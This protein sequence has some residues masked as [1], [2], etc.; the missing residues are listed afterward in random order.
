MLK[1]FLETTGKRQ[2]K[3]LYLYSDG[4]VSETPL[5]DKIEIGRIWG[6]I[7]DTEDT[8]TM[9]DKCAPYIKNAK[10]GDY[11]YSDGKISSEYNQFDSVAGIV[12]WVSFGTPKSGKRALCITVNAASLSWGNNVFTKSSSDEDGLLNTKNIIKRAEE[13]CI[14]APAAKF[15]YHYEG[16]GLK[17]GECYL[18][19]INELKRLQMAHNKVNSSLRAMDVSMPTNPF[20]LSSTEVDE[21]F[22]I[23]MQLNSQFTRSMQKYEAWYV[24]PVFAL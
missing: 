7:G 1:N 5:L 20:H 22:V 6:N 2:H 4:S 10:I 19:A 18:P 14:D 8:K 23:A 9:A 24:H 16:N 12:F 11:V 15:C 3:P 17:Q 13:L 21:K